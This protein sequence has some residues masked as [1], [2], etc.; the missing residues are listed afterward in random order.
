MGKQDL[1]EKINLKGLTNCGIGVSP[2]ELDLGLKEIDIVER[3][4]SQRSDF[5][6]SYSFEQ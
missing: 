3:E 6:L 2:L 1:R 4:Y 5:S